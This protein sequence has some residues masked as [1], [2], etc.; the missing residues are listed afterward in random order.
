MS[1]SRFRCKVTPTEVAVDY[2]LGDIN[3]EE[4]N[5]GYQHGLVSNKLT[6]FKKSFRLGFRQAK[7]EL[8]ALSNV[9]TFG[10][11]KIKNVQ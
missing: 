7:L 1:N 10:S 6:E 8:R 11:I 3:A 5:R 9:T 2:S 4:Y